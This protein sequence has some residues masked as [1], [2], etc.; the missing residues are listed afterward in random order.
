MSKKE[1]SFIKDEVLGFSARIEHTENWSG[2]VTISWHAPCGDHQMQH[3]MVKIPGSLLL[4]I[5][6]AHT[7]D[8]VVSF[9]ASAMEEFV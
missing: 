3:H 4:A 2:D 7:K 1:V 9:L 6:R 5:V 8:A